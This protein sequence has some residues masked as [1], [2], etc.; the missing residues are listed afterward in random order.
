[1][2]SAG[3]SNN[4]SKRTTSSKFPSNSSYTSHLGQ[5]QAA[6][7]K[8]DAAASNTKKDELL[9]K[10]EEYKRLNAELEKKTANLV[11]EAEQVL[12]ANEKLLSDTD[13]LNKVADIDM[14]TMGL[15]NRPPAQAK[16]ASNL[17]NQTAKFK[18][19]N[20][21]D[22][23]EI[24]RI[25]ANI[26]KE[27]R[28]NEADEDAA[29]SGI[30]NEHETDHLAAYLAAEDS[31]D[32]TSMIPRAVNDMSNEAQIRFLKAKLKVMQEE[33][34]RSGAELSRKDEENVK[35]A[36]RCKDLDEDRAK[37]L[38][39]S[40]SHQTQLEKLKKINEEM[41]AKLAQSE[42]Q[43][44]AAKKESESLRRELKKTQQEQQQLEL[45]QNRSA[46]EVDRL[47]LEL[48]KHI[49]HK[50]DGSEQD[51]LKLDSLSSENKRLQ[52]QKVELIQ[53][54]KKQ[55]KLIDILKKQKMHLEAAK[56]LQFSEQEFINALEW[57]SNQ[58]A[59]G[60]NGP[61]TSGRPPSSTG[62]N[63]NL[64]K[65]N[66]GAAGGKN[67][68]SVAGAGGKVT[69]KPPMIR[70][71]S[72]EMSSGSKENFNPENDY[73]NNMANLGNE[74]NLDDENDDDNFER[75]DQ[76]YNN[77]EDDDELDVQDYPNYDSDENKIQK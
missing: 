76:P 17:S 43:S 54:F 8:L 9:N 63:R 56:I 50:K 48:S 20:L 68:V 13:Y 38:R 6:S 28:E 19:M 58:T 59:A 4:T 41:Q 71:K 35:L 33:L 44:Q 53:A 22:F 37:Q 72:D 49:T 10:E 45:K 67:N 70:S 47:K 2:S 77:N 66:A 39:I 21:L 5:R 27:M 36:Q 31:E 57:N 62:S 1:M 14:S 64:S 25:R 40:N 32:R 15:G 26:N 73:G 16:V 52:K 75:F 46:E 51:K 3:G 69:Q 55:L 24:S 29:V 61:K 23:D 7:A 12:K 60:V 30:G 42:S 65:P 34:D 11:Y 18:A 74:D